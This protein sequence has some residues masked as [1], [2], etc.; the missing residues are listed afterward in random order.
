MARTG[1]L[2]RRISRKSLSSAFSAGICRNWH[3]TG[4][5]CASSVCAPR[6]GPRTT[7]GTGR[8]RHGPRTWTRCARRKA[9]L[10]RAMPNIRNIESPITLIAHSRSGT[11][12]LLR[13]FGL[14]P[15]VE[16]VGETANL[17]FTTWRALEQISGL[18]RYGNADCS[19]DAAVL[20]RNAFLHAFPSPKRHWMH[21]PIGVPRI[22][23]DSRRRRRGRLRRVVL[24]SV[25]GKLSGFAKFRSRA[26]PARH[27]HQREAVPRLRRR[28]DLAQSGHDVS[29]HDSPEGELP[30]RRQA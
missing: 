21:K 6:A 8:S 29:H 5:C 13:A 30:D 26:Q 11:S 1:S 19:A 9:G 14:H 10:N 15:D 12:V 23:R 20:V 22:H 4:A 18:T 24:A 17:V 28:A 27:L 25:Q 3:P 16:A 7:A 2:F